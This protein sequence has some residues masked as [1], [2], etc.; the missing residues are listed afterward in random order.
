M[1]LRLRARIKLHTEK[2]ADDPEIGEGRPLLIRGQDLLDVMVTD[3]GDGQHETRHVLTAAVSNDH[4]GAAGHRAAVGV[5]GIVEDPLPRH[6]VHAGEDG[7]GEVLVDDCGTVAAGDIGLVER[8]AQHAP[9]VDTRRADD[10]VVL[11]VD[12][13]DAHLAEA[14]R[15]LRIVPQ[16]DPQR[17]R[18]PVIAQEQVAV[19]AE[20]A[21]ARRAAVPRARQVAKDHRFIVHLAER[22]LHSALRRADPDRPARQP[23]GASAQDEA[24]VGLLRDA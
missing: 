1:G 6:G 2:V 19:N 7:V 17:R 14:H 11:P 22:R 12:V 9:L 13:D 15:R 5:D 18:P 23:Q 8:V 24:S 3:V 4:Q 20:P 21:F 10:E 16:D